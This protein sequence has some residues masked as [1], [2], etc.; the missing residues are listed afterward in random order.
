MQSLW[1]RFSYQYYL[2]DLQKSF[3]IH[4]E[5]YDLFRDPNSDPE[6]VRTLVED[7]INMALGRFLDYLQKFEPE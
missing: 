3:Q 4:Q 5:I 2:E 1:H 7:H 6:H